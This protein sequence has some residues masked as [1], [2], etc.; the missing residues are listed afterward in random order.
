LLQLKADQPE[1]LWDP[2]LP[3][4]ARELSSTLARL[5][6][7]LS[8]PAFLEPFRSHWQLEA[9]RQRRRLVDF[10]RPTIAMETYL[11]L[12][13]IRHRTGW[14][15]ETLVK[16]VSDSFHLRRFC[17]L[18]FAEPVPDESTIRK[19][20]RRLGE[21][22][23][24]ALIA[25]GIR[26]AMQKRGFR[27][28]AMRCDSTV[29]AADIRFPTDIRLVAEAV[30]T[31][32]RLAKK[33]HAA[34]PDLQ[35]RVRDRS[36]KLNELLRLLGRSLIQRTGMAKSAVEQFTTAAAE[37][38][39]Y[40]LK[41]ARELLA[42][43]EAS[44][45]IAVGVSLQARARA[46]RELEDCIRLSER[47]AEQVRQRFAGEKIAD[48]LISLFDP[49]AR[50]I[51]RGKLGNPNEFGYMVQLAEITSHTRKGARGLIVPPQLRPGSTH[52]NKLLPG[53]AKWLV[54]LAIK[55]KEA[56]FD[57]G[58]GI[59]ATAAEI[60]ATGAAIFIAGHHYH[61]SSRTRRRLARYRVGC[62][63]R[64]SH[65]KREHGLQR[66]R[67]KGRPGAQTWAN[68]SVLT[69]NLETI[70]RLKV[71]SKTTNTADDGDE[72]GPGG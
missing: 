34:V 72:Y 7:L 24:E 38:L 2:L 15:Y 35:P 26:V 32:A 4:G 54:D 45:T 41:E 52:D 58:F 3:A 25:N 42:E 49:D 16:E 66:T 69:Y 20:T 36:R 10:G 60:A 70:A 43:A 27:P 68:W 5:D 65:L 53:T 19:L 37:R 51:R 71:K 29:L 39:Q 63:G 30:R 6:E 46:I 31:L 1:T 47:V 62:E 14:G 56:V 21:K 9:E 44:S 13:F 59:K 67:L 11:R 50:V 8:E 17:R 64:I 57:G 28:R 33:V 55:L 18:D 23:V 12:M 48:R 22:V 40:S 61:G